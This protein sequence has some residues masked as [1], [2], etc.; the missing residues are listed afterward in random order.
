MTG[1]EA[2]HEALAEV[3][4]WLPIICA[5]VE[6]TRV[7]CRGLGHIYGEIKKSSDIVLSEALLDALPIKV[8]VLDLET[9]RQD[10]DFRIFYQ[11]IPQP[12]L[13][14]IE[15]EKRKLRE[16][17]A[18]NN[19]ND[20][21]LRIF[22]NLERVSVGFWKAFRDRGEHQPWVDSRYNMKF[23]RPTVG[24]V[25]RHPY[26]WTA[27]CGLQ[28]DNIQLPHFS[29]R[30]VNYTKPQETLAR[31]ELLAITAYMEWRA[32]QPEYVE[33]YYLPVLCI[34]VFAGKARLLLAY[35]DGKNLCISKSKLYDFSKNQ[36]EN[37]ELLARWMY[38]KPCGDTDEPLKIEAPKLDKQSKK[39][40]KRLLRSVFGVK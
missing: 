5:R 40:L 26:A 35:H 23:S 18:D 24:Y 14:A 11:P 15:W 25:P 31:G 32:K 34:S 38:S 12:K 10:A 3:Q 21:A 17:S 13:P 16:P 4:K 20:E 8:S 22:H 2:D 1:N 39:H 29:F 36:I 30:L 9:G 6:K 7:V 19:D 37:Y 33:R 28:V 27:N